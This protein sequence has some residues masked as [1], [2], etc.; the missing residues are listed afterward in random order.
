VNRPRTK[1][2]MPIPT[3]HSHGWK[4]CKLGPRT[5][6]DEK[7]LPVV[8]VEPT[9]EVRLL[10]G[11]GDEAT[12]CASN[13]CEAE[14]VCHAQ[15]ELGFGVEEGYG[16]KAWLNEGRW[17]RDGRALTQVERHSGTKP[18][19]EDTEANTANNEARKVKGSRH[20]CRADCPTWRRR[21]LATFLACQGKGT[22]RVPMAT[23]P[24]QILGLK[25]LEVMVAGTW[26]RT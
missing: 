21:Q 17:G 3:H 16:R 12:E 19:L 15:P 6:Y 25:S 8:A 13:G 7:Q 11:E 26:M 2:G 9:D 4:I 10:D 5:F 1:A 22:E 23:H 24:S 14:P 20:E 18:S